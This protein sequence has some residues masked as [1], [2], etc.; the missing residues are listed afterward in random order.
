MSLG[1]VPPPPIITDERFNEA[2]VFLAESDISAAKL[3]ADME[4]A[5]FKAKS[6]RHTTY[7]HMKGATVA[8]REA[9]AMAKPE[10]QAAYEAYFASIQAYN[11]VANKRTTEAIVV[12]C[13]R[14]INA[15]RRMGTV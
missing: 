15:N 9:M 5:E 1:F 10:V 12:D 8:E 7:L 14:S 2:L 6:L 3:K 13:W 4:R 11:T